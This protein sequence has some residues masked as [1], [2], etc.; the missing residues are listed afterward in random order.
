[1]RVLTHDGRH[2]FVE[3]R[4]IEILDV[5]K[6]KLRISP[7]LRDFVS[8]FGHSLALSAWSR[9]SE[10]DRNSKHEFLHSCGLDLSARIDQFFFVYCRGNS[11]SSL[12]LQPLLDL[13]DPPFARTQRCSAG[14]HRV[15]SEHEV[16]R[17]RGSRTDNKIRIG[18]RV[19]ID[20]IVRRLEDRKFTGFHRVRHKEFAGAYRKPTNRMVDV[21]RVAPG[22][23]SSQAHGQVVQRARSLQ[24]ACC[25]T[26]VAD[27]NTRRTVARYAIGRQVD[28]FHGAEFFVRRQREPELEPSGMARV[29]RSAT[30]PRSMSRFE[31]F[32]AAFPQDP[33]CSVRIFVTDT[34]F[35]KIGHRRNSR[36]GMKADSGKRNLIHIEE[37]QEHKRF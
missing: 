1:M 16:V 9:A 37:I 10:N 32:D 12:V 29:A 14:V 17:V 2:G 20:G 8:P 22:F 24:R 26:V 21:R 33:G 3:E 4:E 35:E 6:F 30:V 7:F 5:N 23:P 19:N 13:V 25:L 36:V 15:L 27:Q 11:K 18:L 34:S 28:V 31:P